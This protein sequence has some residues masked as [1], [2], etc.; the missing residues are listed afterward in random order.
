MDKDR[1]VECAT[2]GFLCKH[3]LPAR[4]VPRP[5]FYEAEE[6]ERESKLALFEHCPDGFIGP[7]GT[8][9]VC[10]MR[11]I[12]IPMELTRAE[13]LNGTSKRDSILPLIQ[14]QRK[15]DKWREYTPGLSP[16]EHFYVMQFEL[17]Q[18]QQRDWEIKQEESRRRFDKTL[19]RYSRRIENRYQRANTRLIWIGI[20][21]GAIFTAMQ[22]LVAVL[23]TRESATD[24]LI[25][26]LFGI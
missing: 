19:W 18:K 9:P 25:R 26:L 17:L 7:I 8:E 1:L 15:R 3:A 11:K 13:I 10:F 16:R 24:R 22:I 23:Y 2:C 21:A 12:D 4:P 14:T 5:A 20:V 6:I